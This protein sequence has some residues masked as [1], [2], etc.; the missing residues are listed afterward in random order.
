MKIRHCVLNCGSTDSFFKHHVPKQHSVD[1]WSPSRLTLTR[2][3]TCSCGQIF[4]LYPVSL[5]CFIKWLCWSTTFV[6]VSSDFSDST[7][8]RWFSFHHQSTCV[9]I[10]IFAC[11]SADLRGH[12]G[13]SSSSVSPPPVSLLPMSLSTVSNFVHCPPLHPAPISSLIQPSAILTCEIPVSSVQNADK[14]GCSWGWTYV[15]NS[16]SVCPEEV[17]SNTAGNSTEGRWKVKRHLQDIENEASTRDS[18]YNQY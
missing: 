1:H 16:D 11:A 7:D 17:L 3:H 8:H 9:W 10:D 4:S 6:S 13:G 14:A 12:T 15:W 2:G 5:V 18:Q